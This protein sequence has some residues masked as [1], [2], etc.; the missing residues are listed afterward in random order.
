M[1]MYASIGHTMRSGIAV[2]DERFIFSSFSVIEN[3][4]SQTIYSDDA[5][6]FPTLSQSPL[7]S[8]PYPHPFCLSLEN[9]LTS[10]T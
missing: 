8:L 5:L 3:S 1:K 2:L 10:K 4:F 6:P 9:Q 7:H